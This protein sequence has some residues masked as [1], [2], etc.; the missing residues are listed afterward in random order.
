MLRFSAIMMTVLASVSGCTAVTG[1]DTA[2]Q[3]VQDG[4]TAARNKI[5]VGLVAYGSSPD[6]EG[7]DYRDV[8]FGSDL[9]AIGSSELTLDAGINQMYRRNRRDAV[10]ALI[11][12]GDKATQKGCRE[13]ARKTYLKVIDTYS[14]PSD[15]LFRQRAKIGLDDLRAMPAAV[16]PSVQPRRRS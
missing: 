8:S 6:C 2:L 9:L 14:Q 13:A 1:Y 12:L 5:Q 11:T 7:A 3:K 16:S 10:G 15:E 4:N